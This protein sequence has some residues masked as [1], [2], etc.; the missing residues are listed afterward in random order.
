MFSFL[1][2]LGSTPAAGSFAYE[3]FNKVPKVPIGGIAQFL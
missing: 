2:C 1:S 3:V